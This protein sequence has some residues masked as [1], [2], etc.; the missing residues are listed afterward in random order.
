MLPSPNDQD[1]R[2]PLHRRVRRADPRRADDISMPR[3]RRR[4]AGGTSGALRGYGVRQPSR[5]AGPAEGRRN[6]SRLTTKISGPAR[7]VRP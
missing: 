1:Q 7:R 2:G 3:A 4:Q 5:S 6:R